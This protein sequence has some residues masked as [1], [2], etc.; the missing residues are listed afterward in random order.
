MK[1]LD[2]LCLLY[3]VLYDLRLSCSTE[4]FTTTLSKRGVCSKRLREKFGP[5]PQDKTSREAPIALV[6]MIAYNVAVTDPPVVEV[7]EPTC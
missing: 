1:R 4:D 7:F 2:T 5:R 6:C 3:E